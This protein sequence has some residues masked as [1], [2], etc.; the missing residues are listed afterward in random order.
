MQGAL[1]CFAA[2]PI[3]ARLPSSIRTSTSF[4]S[5]PGSSAETRTSLRERINGIVRR[6]S[7]E[8]VHSTA[9]TQ[10]KA[11]R[12][13]FAQ[14]NVDSCHALDLPYFPFGERMPPEFSD[15]PIKLCELQIIFGSSLLCLSRVP[16]SPRAQPFPLP[17][18]GLIRDEVILKAVG[19][20][21]LT[22]CCRQPSE[23]PCMR[24]QWVLVSC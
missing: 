4:W 23:L 21:P 17:R 13:G 15:Q 24:S 9:R 1:N 16:S 3:R 8:E 2:A 6:H 7:E 22:S 12:L 18:T 10:T 5:R 14:R 19:L 20:E 11:F